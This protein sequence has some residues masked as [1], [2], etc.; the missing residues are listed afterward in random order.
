MCSTNCIGMTLNN[1]LT[2]LLLDG[3]F[4]NYPNTISAKDLPCESLAI[5][6]LSWLL[7]L[8]SSPRGFS[9]DSLVFP[10][11]QKATF[12][13]FNSTTCR[14]SLKTT[15]VWVE[16]PGQILPLDNLLLLLLLSLLLL[17]DAGSK[18]GIIADIPVFFLH[19]IQISFHLQKVCL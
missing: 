3:G 10:S 16:L 2:L 14:T 13:N 6:G 7:V 12:S 19:W 4:F 15:L 9:L 1:N 5:C 8:Y 17:F 11:P 18:L